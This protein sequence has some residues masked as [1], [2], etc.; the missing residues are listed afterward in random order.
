MSVDQG[1]SVFTEQRG[2]RRG[3]ILGFTMAESMLLLVFCLL[4]A[5]GALIFKAQ[6]QLK[7]SETAKAEIQAQLDESKNKL[8]ILNE[9]LDLA[10]HAASASADVSET[11]RELSIART[12]IQRLAE[13]SLTLEEVV[14]NAAMLREI[15]DSEVTP[16]GRK[17][18]ESILAELQ[19]KGLASEAFLDLLKAAEQVTK[20]QLTEREAAEFAAAADLIRGTLL[21]SDSLTA[22]ES[23]EK[24]V[25][26]AAANKANEAAL[27]T[28]T[29]AR[30]AEEKPHDWPPI[31]NLSETKGYFFRSGSAELDSRFRQVLLQTVAQQIAAT[32]REYGVDVVE[33]IGHTDEQRMGKRPSNLD[34]ELKN[35]LGGATA[36]AALQ[37]GDNAGLGLARAV[38]VTE[39]LKSHPDLAGLTILPMS[40]AQLILPSDSL[41]DGAHLGDVA[42][43]R[44]IEIRVRKRN[45]L[46][47]S[48][49]PKETPTRRGDTVER[50][51]PTSGQP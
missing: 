15:L 10:L 11:W 31:I 38:A 7:A 33:V 44:R 23:L 5:A 2:Y 50:E 51:E 4:L 8:A 46:A 13:H 35:V 25:S 37:P 36:V 34:D 1:S 40:G 19:A 41:T 21:A 32:A 29:E 27:K 18:A 17:R 24:L 43:R 26:Q 6:E 3:L 22:R 20:L 42:S 12:A 28:L 30:A 9:Q 39:A 47:P 16:E 14:D 48:A 49:D 45:D